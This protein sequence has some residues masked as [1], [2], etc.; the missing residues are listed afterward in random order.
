[1]ATQTSTLQVKGKLG[2]IVGYKGRGK[3]LAR[4]RATEIKNPNTAGQA[5]QRMITATNARAYSRLKTICDHSFEGVA[6]KQ[7]SQD[8]FLKLNAKLLRQWV[9]GNLSVIGETDLNKWVGLSGIDD[10][11]ATGVGLQISKGSLPTVPAVRWTENDNVLFGFGSAVSSETVS[12]FLASLGAV[13]GDQISVVLMIKGQ[14]MLARYVTS[15][16]ATA[17]QLAAA[18]SDDSLRAIC[19]GRSIY[20][21]NVRF[22]LSAMVEGS[23]ER[24]VVIYDSEGNRLLEYGVEGAAIILSRKDASGNWLRSTQTLIWTGDEDVSNLAAPW[25][26]IPQWQSGKTEIDVANPYY[27]NQANPTSAV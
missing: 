7:A 14:I 25:M 18:F 19:T 26:V 17:E 5:I 2:N 6:Y 24:Y 11:Y 22:S 4:I 20:S 13:P 10:F 8:Y 1:M 21:G 16:N 15:A 27:L 23:E 12:S 3:Q 9:A